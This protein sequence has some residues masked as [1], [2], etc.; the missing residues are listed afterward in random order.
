[1]RPRLTGLWQNPDFLKLWT[2]QTVSVFGTLITRTALPFTAI[3][4]LEARPFQVAVLGTTDIV[5]GILAGLFAGVWVDRLRR[6]PLM[7]ATDILRAALLLTIPLAAALDT[8][9]I[10]HL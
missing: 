5:A 6:R 3:L 8:L 10:E 7:V 9:R 2:G 4:A 1:M